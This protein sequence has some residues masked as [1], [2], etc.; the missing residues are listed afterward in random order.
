MCHCDPGFANDGLKQCSRCADPL[1]KFPD[2]QVRNWVIDEPDVNCKELEYRM[3]RTMYL[4]EGGTKHDQPFQSEEGVLNWA[5]RYR[6]SDGTSIRK[7]STH[8]F[9]VPTN[10]VMRIFV[11]NV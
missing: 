11:D 5:K 3:P 1:F 7:S 6:L 8:W 2:C 10:S 9:L 4:A